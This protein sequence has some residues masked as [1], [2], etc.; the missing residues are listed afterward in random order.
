GPTG[1]AR[2]G[3]GGLSDVRGSRSGRRGLAGATGPRRRFLP[4]GLDA[5]EAPDGE[6][7]DPGHDEDADDEVAGGVDVEVGRHVP[8]ATGEP[9][10]GPEDREQLDGADEGGHGDRQPG[11][12]E[13]VVHLA[14][15]PGEG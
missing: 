14:N 4:A 8:D 15:G 7:C 1:P 5:P 10:L 9:E 12:G 11:D 6:G 3:R 13:V 2:P